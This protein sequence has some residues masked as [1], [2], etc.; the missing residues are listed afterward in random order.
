[1][2]ITYK[3]MAMGQMLMA[4]GEADIVRESKTRMAMLKADEVYACHKKITDVFPSSAW[5]G[6]RC[7][8]IGGG[9]SIKGID[10]NRLK[11]EHVIGVNRSFEF[12]DTEILFL[13][14]IKFH[15]EVTKGTLNEYTKKD[16]KKKWDE[17]KGVKVLLCPV[18]PYPLDSTIHMVRRIERK[19]VSL[20]ISEGVYGGSNSGFGAL[21]LAIAM[22]A[23]PIYLLGYDL[24]V[25]HFTHWH[26]GY[27]KQ[28]YYEQKEKTI[29]FRDGF[30]EFSK[31]IKSLGFNV[32]NLFRDSGINCFE[33]DDI[34]AVLPKTKV[35]MK[36]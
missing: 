16:V 12:V 30:M 27:P 19:Y 15:D 5:Q 7:F 32:V 36:P 35:E 29:R 1:M 20:D 28:T 26:S 2:L 11:G 17:F 21:M 10:F 18:S 13:M 23:N 34:D 6:K 33:F 22:G 24:R 9:E 31:T 4:K 14:D 25:E 8:I 3:G